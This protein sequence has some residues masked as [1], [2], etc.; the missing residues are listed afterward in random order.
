[1]QTRSW[2][3]KRGH[4]G[5]A[6]SNVFVVELAVLL[7]NGITDISST[8]IQDKRDDVMLRARLRF[9]RFT[10]SEGEVG[11]KMPRV[12]LA[13]FIVGVFHSSTFSNLPSLP[14]LT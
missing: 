6:H 11:H 2:L 13:R 12:T 5:A 14:L 10:G 4:L 1:M 7:M 3:H 8:M 9:I